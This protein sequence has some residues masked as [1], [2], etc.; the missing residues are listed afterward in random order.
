M[1]F[2]VLIVDDEKMPR[3][4]LHHYIPWEEYGV[5]SIYEAQDGESALELAS[6]KKPDI[7]ISDIKMPR[8]NG[9]SLAEEV[10]RILPD[11][12]FIFLSGYSDK[13]YLKGAIRLKAASYVEKPIDLD[14][15]RGVLTEVCEQL[16]STRRPDPEIL[17]FRGGPDNTEPLNDCIFTPDDV[18]FTRLGEAVRHK[19]R[20]E[21]EHLLEPLYRDLL[22]CEGTPPDTVR[23]LYCRIVFLF[24]NAAE[25]RNL[26][27]VAAA[28]NDSL[29]KI[30][31]E[32]TLSGLHAILKSLCVMY[33]N[34]L[35]SEEPDPL[36][37]VNQYLEAHWS[38]P[39]LTVLDMA[40]ALG[41]T[42]T[43]LCAAYKK[44]CGRTINQQ[45]TLL[46]LE[47]A[48][49]LLAHSSLRLYEV[50]RRVGYADGKYFTRVFTR[51][52]GM[53]PKQYRERHSHDN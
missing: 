27:P 37:R 11:C 36:T 52:T 5:R 49:D 2:S 17:F 7:I 35:E 50:G 33:F 46:R 9:L 40:Q 45:I 3:E 21:T 34:A 31:G 4:S 24:I 51:E 41:F 30:A 20:H 29:L 44:S 25:S 53:T 19:N 26:A 43:Y 28:G 8:R 15:I 14:E 16:R 47:H 38:E 10:R 13:E 1:C 39:E 6:E 32:E 42:N 22:R 18:L 12:Q 48:K 23:S